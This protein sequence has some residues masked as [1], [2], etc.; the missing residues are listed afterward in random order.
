MNHMRINPSSTDQDVHE[1]KILQ[2]K[3]LVEGLINVYLNEKNLKDITRV[4]EILRDK[5]LKGGVRHE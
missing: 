3:L 5:I 4:A 1:W 2:V